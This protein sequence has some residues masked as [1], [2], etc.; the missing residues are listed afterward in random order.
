MDTAYLVALAF[1]QGVTEF[2]PISSS[3]HLV[4]AN[5]LAP[6][7]GNPASVIVALHGA[8]LL[9]LL[10]YFFDDIRRLLHGA[11]SGQSGDRTYVVALGIATLPM[12]VA[13][14]FLYE[15]FIQSNDPTMV[16]AVLIVSG[17]SLFVADRYAQS[18]QRRTTPLP[19]RGLVIGLMQLL[20]VI[21]GVS[22]SGITM[23]AGRLVGFSRNE[24]V[25]FSFLLG[26][27]VIFGAQ[28]WSVVTILRGS[29]AVLPVSPLALI[30]AS[31][32]TFFLA[33]G[34]VRL[35]LQVIERIGFAPFCVYQIVLGTLV[36]VTA[37]AQ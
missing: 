11:L 7:S 30:G 12:I 5:A 28:V 25:R 26:I 14:A 21:P 35:L 22:R 8:T 9:A 27:P 4:L 10:V 18:T 31:A 32:I 3:A 1:L 37:I 16:A 20:A 19:M 36:L 6:Q 33:L 23:T 34:V 29:A 13:G 15:M 17:L 24:A 2:L